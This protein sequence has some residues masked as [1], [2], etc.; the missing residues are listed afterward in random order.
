M[1]R[2]GPYCR[3]PGHG[4]SLGCQ[5]QR[6][7]HPALFRS[8]RVNLRRRYSGGILCRCRHHRKL[9][10]PLVWSAM[11]HHRSHR[12]KRAPAPCQGKTRHRARRRIHPLQRRLSRHRRLRQGDAADALF[13]RHRHPCARHKAPSR[14]QRIRLFIPHR[15]K[16]PPSSP[17]PR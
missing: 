13:P 12:N 17:T 2:I 15:R 4:H 3:S 14:Q 1:G 16:A 7:C 9:H 6:R 8:R 10:K 5:Q 11:L